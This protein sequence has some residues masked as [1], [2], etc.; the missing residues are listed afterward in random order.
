MNAPVTTPISAEENLSYQTILKAD[1]VII[2]EAFKLK[3]LFL[4]A[5]KL[6]KNALYTDVMKHGK[7]G[8]LRATIENGL[9]LNLTEEVKEGQLVSDYDLMTGFKNDVDFEAYSP[10]QRER[11]WKRKDV[12]KTRIYR[13]RKKIIHSWNLRG[14][15]T[16]KHLKQKKTEAKSK[17]ALQAG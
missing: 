4:D 7:Y 10:E 16:P 17:K 15:P 13:L 1:Y 12:L 8:A 9:I 3:N 14:M 5:K 2:A 6:K 11:L